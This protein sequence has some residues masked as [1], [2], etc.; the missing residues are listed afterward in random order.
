MQSEDSVVCVP[1]GMRFNEHVKG[2]PNLLWCK[3]GV[4][5]HVLAIAAAAQR[6]VLFER[7]S[8]VQLA[9]LAGL[10]GMTAAIR[11]HA[12]CMHC[13]CVR[14]V[15]VLDEAEDNTHLIAGTGVTA[16]SGQRCHAFR[17][18]P[19]MAIAHLGCRVSYAA[20]FPPWRASYRAYVRCLDDSRLGQK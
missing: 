20:A 19:A 14:I 16:G 1:L 13:W 18:P 15:F 12:C 8:R 2:G 17:Q 4:A 7:L 3:R 11:S 10:D 5:L 6:G 9:T